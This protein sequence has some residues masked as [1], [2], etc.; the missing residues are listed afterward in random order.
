VTVF[1]E[2]PMP[3]TLLGMLIAT[4]AVIA[5][6]VVF[7]DVM[8]AMALAV[9]LVPLGALAGWLAGRLLGRRPAR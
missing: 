1:K 6:A 7:P 9:L 8:T 4:L 3:P 5:V 2:D